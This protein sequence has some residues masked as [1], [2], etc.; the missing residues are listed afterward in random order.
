MVDL[1]AAVD[2]LGHQLN[3]GAGVDDVVEAVV[4]LEVAD[5][6]DASRR[7]IV[8]D[9]DFVAAPEQLLGQVGADEAGAAGDEITHGDIYLV[10]LVSF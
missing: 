3:I 6:V 5:V 1:V 10:S 2:Q 8:D 9:E 4:G 7:Q